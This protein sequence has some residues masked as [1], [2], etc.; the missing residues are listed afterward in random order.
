MK[1]FDA[2]DYIDMSKK[3]LLL[4]II[5]NQTIMSVEL[6]KLEK[7]V[8][9]NGT[10]ISSAVTLISGLKTELQAVKDELAAQGVTSAKLNE[11]AD[12]LD[13]NEQALATA[14]AANTSSEEEEEGGTV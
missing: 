12:A 8:Q 7:E 10:V 2:L 6:D 4:L 1:R 3:K 11:L 14:V 5:K 13:A 9:E